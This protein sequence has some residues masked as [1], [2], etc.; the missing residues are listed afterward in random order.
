M[1][2]DSLRMLLMHDGKIFF[3]NIHLLPYWDKRFFFLRE[4]INLIGRKW[5]KLAAKT[6]AY[7]LFL[8]VWFCYTCYVSK[9]QIAIKNGRR[10]A[11]DGADSGF[12]ERSIHT[13]FFWNLRYDTGMYLRTYDHEFT[14]SET[15]PQTGEGDSKTNR[16]ND[17]NVFWT[18]EKYRTEYRREAQGADRQ[19][20]AE[21]EQKRAIQ[22]TGGTLRKCDPGDVSVTSFFWKWLGKSRIKN[23]WNVM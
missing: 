9:N 12:C 11:P 17:K 8:C 4:N 19:C 20:W 13:A 18:E 23:K 16:R 3:L 22:R 2:Y 10:E 21:T 6:W 14:C 5:S 7:G 15:L 1:S